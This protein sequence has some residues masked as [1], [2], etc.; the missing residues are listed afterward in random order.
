[1]RS[2]LRWWPALPTAFI[3]YFGGQSFLRKYPRATDLSGMSRT[4]SAPDTLVAL[5]EAALGVSD[6]AS[7]PS[8]SQAYA[9]PFRP[10]IDRPPAGQTSQTAPAPPPRNYVLK[11]TVGSSV[12]T[13]A[14]N[15][16]TKLIV[17]VGDAVDSAVVV[18]IEPNKVV[19]KDRGGK[20]DLHPEK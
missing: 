4:D 10:A 9:N 6:S 1:M 2:L 16:G 17:K 12:A 15:A 18:S 8:S 13:I 14:N 19:L 5:A 3:L 20:F 7:T 11:G